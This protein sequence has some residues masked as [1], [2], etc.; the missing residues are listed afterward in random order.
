V[1]QQIG[2]FY[3]YEA[4]NGGVDAP[5]RIARKTLEQAMSLMPFLDFR[6]G[7]YL[8]FQDVGSVIVDT[9]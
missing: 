5:R 4:K 9:G 7:I 8:P 2:R 3:V 6:R 1:L